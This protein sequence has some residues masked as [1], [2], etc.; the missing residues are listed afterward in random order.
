MN[1]DKNKK[2]DENKEE[3]KE[4]NYKLLYVAIGCFAVGL[5]M[6]ILTIVFAFTVPNGSAFYFLL[7]SMILELAAIS[8]VNAQK[9]RYGE[10]TKAKIL[11]IACYV[12]MLAGVIIFVFGI[13]ANA[14]ES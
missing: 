6:F 9:Q 3:P 11:R 7:A 5:I 12:I 8:F 13:S 10:G 14:S 2:P 4:I 1:N